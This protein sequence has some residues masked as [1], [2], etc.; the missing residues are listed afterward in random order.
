MPRRKMLTIVLL[1]LVIAGTLSAIYFFN[2]ATS[3]QQTTQTRAEVLQTNTDLCGQMTVESQT[4]FVRNADGT[5][6]DIAATVREDG[7]AYGYGLKIRIKNQKNTPAQLKFNRNTDFCRGPNNNGGLHTD[8]AGPTD[9]CWMGRFGEP[10]DPLFNEVRNETLDF[11]PNETKEIIVYRDSDYFAAC[12]SYQIDFAVEDI[13]MNGTSTGCKRTFSPEAPGGFASVLETKKA[14]PAEKPVC[15]G[16][17]VTYTDLNGQQQT[18]VSRKFDNII[19][20]A[21]GT[22]V[23]HNRLELS[24]GQKTTGFYYGWDVSCLEGDNPTC[25]VDS[26][27]AEARSRG[28]VR[29]LPWCVTASSEVGALGQTNGYPQP[30]DPAN[31]SATCGVRWQTVSPETPTNTPAPT[32]PPAQATNTPVPT[33]PPGQPTRAP[34]EPKACGATACNPAEGANA[35]ATGLECIQAQSGSYVCSRPEYRERCSANPSEGTCCNAPSEQPPTM[36]LNAR[37]SACVRQTNQ[38]SVQGT[39]GTYTGVIYQVWAKKK[40]GTPLS[41]AECP[42]GTFNGPRCLLGTNTAASFSVSTIALA[43]GDYQIY[44]QAVGQSNTILCTN[45]PDTS[46]DVAQCARVCAG[47]ER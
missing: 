41:A 45:D 32:T 47:E 28:G 27:I 4:Q 21:P 44:A 12:G 35:C 20:I 6:R 33:T 22:Q 5:M 40:D 10:E 29:P 30:V 36:I 13:I 39:P 16:M 7:N 17:E 24:N 25:T 2:Q 1:V 38:I 26:L 42:S 43:A 19:Q 37:K 8:P 23:C 14:C 46:S 15:S 9:G 31:A 34:Q 18:T 3:T 11:A